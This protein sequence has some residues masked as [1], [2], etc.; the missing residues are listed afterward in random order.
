MIEYDHQLLRRRRRKMRTLKP[1]NIKRFNQSGGEIPSY[2]QERL[3]YINQQ[4]KDKEN[5]IM[6]AINNSGFA[7]EICYE[8]L[9]TLNQ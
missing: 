2:L 5:E 8:F 7:H 1:K 6:E 4:I 9:D 3:S